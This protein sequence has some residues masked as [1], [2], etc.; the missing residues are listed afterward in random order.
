[1]NENKN[2]NSEWARL[3]YRNQTDGIEAVKK[4]QW[5]TTNYILLIFA[6][7]IGY[8][9]LFIDQTNANIDTAFFLLLLFLT[10]S[11]SWVGIYHL[12]DMHLVLTKYRMKMFNIGK[13]YSFVKE[14]DMIGDSDANFYKYYFSITFIFIAFILGGLSLVIIF[15][16]SKAGKGFSLFSISY[17]LATMLLFDIALLIALTCKKACD[18][19]KFE[20]KLVK[21][22]NKDDSK[23]EITG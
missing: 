6:A 17:C 12:V 19:N 23:V 9:N 10:F 16:Y 7:I 11:L 3:V 18:A 14:I 20:S 15:I 8:L 4:R 2:D 1:M 13:R 22:P 21:K 5:L